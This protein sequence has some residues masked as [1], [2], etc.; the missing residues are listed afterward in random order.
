MQFGGGPWRSGWPRP[1]L[2]S[3]WLICARRCW[4]ARPVPAIG[5]WD[6]LQAIAAEVQALGVRALPVQVDVTDPA[7]IKVMLAR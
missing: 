3:P 6:E 7:F 4:L 1:A 2:I 5:Q